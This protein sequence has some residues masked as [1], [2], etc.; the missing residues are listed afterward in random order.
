M[1]RKRLLSFR[2]SRGSLLDEAKIW[3]GLNDIKVK[4]LKGRIRGRMRPHHNVRDS[5]TGRYI[6]ARRRKASE[7]GFDPKG[8]MLASQT[9][10]NGEVSRSKRENRRTI[11]IRDP[12]TRR[13]KEAEIAIYEPMLDYVED[14]AFADV[15][16]IFMHHFQSDLKGRIKAK[17][18][19]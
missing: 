15:M 10:E 6:K 4:D 12:D 3:F 2:I 8:S 5:T 19:L 7:A 16:A 1:M 11:V 18:N 9:F 13:T 17:I 14:H